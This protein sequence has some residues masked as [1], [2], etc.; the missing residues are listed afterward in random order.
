[1]L[2]TTLSAGAIVHS[3]LLTKFAVTGRYLVHPGILR[4]KISTQQ[5]TWIEMVLEDGNGVAVAL[6]GNDVRL[7][8]AVVE[9]AVMA[10]GGG[11]G[12]RSWD[13]GVGVSVVKA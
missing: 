8:W 4:D 3:A 10:L 11:G 5:S 9:D 6:G 13:D 1:M 7:C 12:R 2:L